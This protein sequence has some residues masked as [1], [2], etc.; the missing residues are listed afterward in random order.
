MNE[1]QIDLIWEAMRLIKRRAVDPRRTV[2]QRMSYESAWTMLWY[3][4]CEN[5]ECL[6]QYDDVELR[7]E[8]C[9]KYDE[10]GSTAMGYSRLS[11]CNACENQ[12][13]FELRG[14]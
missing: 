13:F 8:E 2:E 9:G 14:K 4:L 12:E 11:C 3:A 10:D 6:A 5:Y 1:K 7:C